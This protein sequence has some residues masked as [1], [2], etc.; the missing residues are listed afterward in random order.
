[1]RCTRCSAY[2][3]PLWRVRGTEDSTNRKMC[4]T[5]PAPRRT[6]RPG[7]RDRR[8]AH[9]IPFAHRAEAG[10]PGGR[11]GDAALVVFFSSFQRTYDYMSRRT[12]YPRGP[13]P[14]EG[15]AH[16]SRSAS[17]VGYGVGARGA[18]GGWFVHTES[19]HTC[20]CESYIYNKCCTEPLLENDDGELPPPS[21]QPN[22]C[23]SLT[24]PMHM[25][26]CRQRVR[27]SASASARKRP[28]SALS[29]RL[30]RLLIKRVLRSF[31]R[32]GGIW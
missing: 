2:I 20:V 12:A 32:R 30:T 10:W 26:S 18:S 7:S 21:P 31:S 1:M 22:A 5:A 4:G 14:W 6:A 17:R 9:R 19:S 27:C 25:P 15:S 11:A 3:V 24:V 8:L 13:W 23:S 29:L 28:R 16:G